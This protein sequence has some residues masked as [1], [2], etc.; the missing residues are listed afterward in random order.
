MYQKFKATL[1]AI[2]NRSNFNISPFLLGLVSSILL[3]LLYN[4]SLWRAILERQDSL[5]IENALF[6]T[7]LFITLVL[8]TKLIISIV[9]IRYLFKPMLII[10]FIASSLASY[11]MDSYGIMIEQTM[12]ENVLATDMSESLELFNSSLFFSFIIYGLLP[13]YLIYRCTINYKPVI[14][15]TLTRIGIISITALLLFGNIFLLYPEYS[16]FTREHKVLRFLVNPINY[17]WAVGLSSVNQLSNAM[18]QQL[19]AIGSDATLTKSWQQRGKKSLSILVIGETARAENFSLYNYARKTNP[20]LAKKDIIIFNNVFSCGTTTEVSLPC[21]FSHHERQGFKTSSAKYNENLLDIIKRSGI[22]VLWRENNSGCKG[23]CDRIDTSY[24]AHQKNIPF[25]NDRECF[26]EALLHDIDNYIQQ[27]DG[28]IF[29]VFHQKGSHGPAYHLRYPEK[30]ERFTPV[31]RS[32]QL[33]DCTREQVV[34]AYDNT[35]LYTDFFLSKVIDFLKDRSQEFDTSMI[36]V[37]DHGESLGEQNFYL[38]GLP[39]TF[40]P[41]TQKHVPMMMWFSEGFERS[42]G[43]QRSCIDNK[44]DGAYS[45]DN[46]F[47]SVLGML[48]ITTSALNK[49]LDIFSDCKTENP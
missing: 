19:T 39:Y 34:N 25:C 2:H 40:A 33:Q 28:D 30:F 45:H 15:E 32:N 41:D 48:G 27:Q 23:I 36:Y 18:P 5:N 46:I 17:L 49:E 43:I 29:L 13:S 31:C 35:I 42:Y 1:Q 6:I 38:H 8:L 21:I 20:E 44:R 12:L 26:D 22:S 7:S 9:S 47:H 3:I 16:S 4:N 11:F 14:R 10:L 24:T 37:S